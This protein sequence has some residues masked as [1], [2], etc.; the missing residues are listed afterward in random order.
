LGIL[1]EP[2][3]LIEACQAIDKSGLT[4]STKSAALLSLQ[5]LV[6]DPRPETSIIDFDAS[7]L[8]ARETRFDRLANTPFHA[9]WGIDESGEI[10]ILTVFVLDPLTGKRRH[11]L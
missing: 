9:V 5:S 7:E 8:D 6:S 1:F 4:Q 10:S 2:R 3:L 11:L